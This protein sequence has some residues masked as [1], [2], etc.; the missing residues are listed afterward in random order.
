MN[1]SNM[2]IYLTNIYGRIIENPFW[3]TTTDLFNSF[4]FFPDTFTVLK[5]AVQNH[6]MPFK[7]LRFIDLARNNKMELSLLP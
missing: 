2:D 5:I 6:L 4:L 3:L 7:Y 1:K